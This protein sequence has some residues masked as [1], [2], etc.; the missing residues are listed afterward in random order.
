MSFALRPYQVDIIGQARELMRQGIRSVLIQSPT[1]SGKTLLTAH[2]IGAAKAKGLNAWF[3]VHRRELIKQSIIAFSQVGIPHGVVSAGWMPEHRQAIQIGSIQT[4]I[5][6]HHKMRPPKLIV[7]DECHHIAARSWANL[8][9]AYPQ[10]FLI[11]LTATPER[12]DGTGL[13]KWFKTMVKGPSVSWLIENHFL[14]PYRLYAPSSISTEGIHTRMGDFVQSELSTVVDKPLI[15]GD[16]IKHYRRHCDGKRAVVF[17]VSVM[18]SKHVVEQFNAAGIPA[19]HV[20]GETPPEVR[21]D[22]IK[23]FEQGNVRILSN[24]ELFGEGFD[25]PAIE[26]AILLRPTQSLGLYLQQVG[27]A[28]RPSSGKA[29]AYILDHAGNC[30]R[31][32]LPDDEREWSLAGR[33]TRKD[34]KNGGGA[35]VKVCPKCFAAQFAGRPSCKLCGHVFEIQ[36]REVEE[37]EG[38][39]IE[40]DPA[41]VKRQR[42]FEQSRALDLS[43][44]IELGKKR[45]YKRPELW[46]KHIFNARQARRLAGIR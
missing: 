12:L 3:T 38:D 46:A 17:C 22:A 8:I 20:D 25:L 9:A 42:A 10:A 33:D 37:V 32:G 21:D 31:H 39:L 44:L 29:V 43:A 5:R 26:A 34:S 4:L 1:G 24:V 14:S 28:L 6:R 45:G 41:T 2:M 7:I 19:V 18:H 15:T 35:S 30:Q 23:R 27:R 13:N 36:A 40:V 11:G 16:A